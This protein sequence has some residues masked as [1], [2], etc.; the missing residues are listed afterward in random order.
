W[1]TTNGGATFK[2]VFDRY[3]QSIGAIAVDQANPKTVWVGTGESWVRNSVSAGTGI[4]RSTDA[5]ENWQFMGLPK[6]ERI[7][8]IVID[9]K[10]PNTVYVAVLGALWS[11]GEDRGLYKTTD[12]GKTWQK[13]LHVDAN[14]GCADVQ[15]DPQ[16]TNVVYAA[17]W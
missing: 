5:G 12:A 8:R 4:Y 17:M 13:I 2:P 14:T 11:P 10:S 3:T 16:E 9:P 6:S 7:G 15:I 1:K